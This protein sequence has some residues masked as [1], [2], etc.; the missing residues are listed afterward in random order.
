MNEIKFTQDGK[1]VVVIGDLNQTDKIV[2]EIFVTETGDEIPQGE[3]FVV[4]SLLDAPAISWKQKALLELEKRYDTESKDWDNKIDRMNDNKRIAYAALSERVKWLRSV[5]KESNGKAFKQVISLL[6]DFLSDT[7]KWVVVC[8]YRTYH[9]SKFDE[10]GVSS[11]IDRINRDYNHIRFD[12]MRL[13]SLFGMSDGS[14]VYRV[15][16]Y[17]DGSGSEK[18]VSFFKSKDQAIN[19]IKDKLFN[20]KYYNEKTIEQAKKYGVILDPKKL[21]EYVKTI[22]DNI[23]EEISK[24]EQEI[25]SYKNKLKEIN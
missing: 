3:R 20:E 12:S 24:R 4:K 5:A 14:L 7:E 11:L 17:G 10:D 9:L 2:Q 23:K 6:A 18:D 13:L 22:T 1:K 15:N 25:I 8:D 16:E 19:F 21:D